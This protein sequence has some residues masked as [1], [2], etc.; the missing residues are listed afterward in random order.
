MRTVTVMLI[1][2]M[3]VSLAQAQVVVNPRV[4][5]ND[6]LDVSSAH[7]VVAQIIKP[8]MTDEQKAIACWR[9]MIDHYYHWFPPYEESSPEPVRDLAK[10][11][12]SY[13]FGPCFQNAPVLTALWEAAGFKTRGW[14]ITGH[15]IPEVFYDGAWHMLDADAQAFHRK[16]DGKIASVEE[17]ADD[18]KLFT[19]PPGKSDPYYPF[20]APDVAIAPLIPWGPPSKM[21]DLYASKRDNYRYNKRAVM[22][23]AMYLAL[24]P[25][26]TLTLSPENVGKW[27]KFDKLPKDLVW[28]NAKVAGGPVVETTFDKGP[29]CI[30]GERTFGNGTLAW[31]PDFSTIK[32]DELL[33]LGSENVQLKDGKLV[34][35]DESKPATAVFRVYCPW[36][37]VEA[38]VTAAS[39]AKD[40]SA[41]GYAWSVDG[42]RSWG[43]TGQRGQGTLGRTVAFDL[44]SLSDGQPPAAGR[45]EYLFRV[46][47]DRNSA[48]TAITF[49]NVFQVAPTSLPKLVPGQNKV[50][51]YRGPDEGVVK[52]VQQG[53]RAAKDRFVV[54]SKGLRTP[55]QL[56]TAEA[57]TPGYAVFK[58]TAPNDIVAVSMG[59]QFSVSRGELPFVHADCSFDGGA[60]W[61]EAFKIEKNTNP[62]NTQFEEDVKLAVPAGVQTREA[63]FRYTIRGDHEHKPGKQAATV[64]S[65][66]LYAYYRQPQPD[67]AKLTVELA[68]Q[69][70]AG[71]KWADKKDVSTLDKLPADWTVNCAGDEVKLKSITFRND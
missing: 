11:I 2:L 36:V 20:G 39:E 51:V 53:H 33:W 69:E 7:E 38:K 67:G 50:Q 45:Y 8:G 3:C 18:P 58:L 60:S 24:R 65:I 40:E 25:G 14:T 30:N 71:G 21:M 35:I 44:S 23:H 37:L 55:N 29:V 46:S 1:V 66:R 64:P 5:I 70:K 63:L 62:Q 59:G 19:D 16:A 4:R 6:S 52:L 13:G 17:L 27:F 32:Q 68:W 61:I 56:A 43:S 49:E 34:A 48:L 31:K 41:I 9:F 42:G 57:N 26:E 54:E 28:K 47:L 12:N 15:A 22:G 10:A